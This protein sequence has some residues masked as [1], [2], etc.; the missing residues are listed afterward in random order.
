MKIAIFAG[1]E[2][3]ASID[4]YARELAA[5][6]PPGMDA[7]VVRFSKSPGL[8]G[9][10]YDRYLKYLRVARQ[11]RADYNIIVS[12]SY[13]FLLLGL[14]PERTLIVCHDLHPLI[15]RGWSGTYRL[16]YKLN[17]RFMRRARAIVTVSEHTKKD[18]L[19]Y[20]PFIPPEKV[21][22]IHNGLARKWKRI[23]DED[24]LEQ[25]RSTYGLG[26]KRIILHV[27]NDNWYKNVA[28][29][30]HAFAALNEPDLVLLK[31]GGLGAGNRELVEKLGI[32][33]R[34]VQVTGANDDELMCFY[35][36]AEML[37]FP[38]LH[39]GFG[40]PP[41]E[42]MACGC[43]VITTHRASLT[44]VCGDACLYVDPQDVEGIAGAIHKLANEPP[45]RTALIGRGLQRA[46]KFDWRQTAQAIFQAAGWTL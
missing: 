45:T 29:L 8:K 27:G 41:L 19:K 21:F 46:Q 6:M 37:V 18:L 9:A 23:E 4:R 28:T 3:N 13:S 40:W 16:R 12:E 17:L 7:E 15:Y 44:E 11:T 32:T 31:V 34:F 5:N 35:S 26:G 25:V 38:S 36:L 24:R 30:L 14:P 42:A 10:L 2:G 22:A 1:I 43:P 20:C 33:D 39:E